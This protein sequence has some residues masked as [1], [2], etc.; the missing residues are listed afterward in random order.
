MVDST[1]RVW[2]SGGDLGGGLNIIT[3]ST[4]V[5]QSYHFEEN[6]PTSLASDFV[7]DFQEDAD[8]SVWLATTNGISQAKPAADGQLI[9]QHYQS[10][11]L[12][13]N[14]TRSIQFDRTGKLWLSTTAELAQFNP[15]TAVFTPF[16]LSRGY[17]T[18]WVRNAVLQDT[19]G[20]LYFNSVDHLSIVRPESIRNNQTPPSV[21][22]T[23]ISILNHSLTT[24]IKPK[25]VTLE[26]SVTM[27]THLTLPWQGMMVSFRFSALHFAK[28]ALNHYAYKLEGFNQ[29]WVK[30]DSSDRVATYTNLDPGEYLFRV[31]ASNN[32][33]IW[34]EIGIN[35]PITITPPYWQTLWFR[36]LAFSAIFTLLLSLYFWRTQQLKKIQSNLELQVD[37]RTKELKKAHQQALAAAQVKSDFLANISHEIRTPMNAI[38][39]MNHLTL[40]TELTEQQRNYQNKINSSA[41]WLLDML[42]DILDFS[43]LEAG[44]IQL[45]YTYFNLE[46]IMQSL[47]DIAVSL[48]AN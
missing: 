1:G 40:Q 28:P 42:N 45:E 18:N 37:Q 5:L 34:N 16:S 27:P 11:D 3:P 46:S 17:F 13:S 24:S 32:T 48:L 44:K 23:D 26:G 22:I 33:G 30:T 38:L 47:D 21:A 9:F 31:K 19:E 20:N 8:G 43:K 4:G 41:N 2:V 7:L 35:L 15:K 6:N 12:K 36:F 39:G 14:N 10:N 25:G 29:D